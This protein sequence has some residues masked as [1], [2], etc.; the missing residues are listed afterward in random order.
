MEIMIIIVALIVGILPLKTKK[1]L[2]TRS[3]SLMIAGVVI[4][5]AICLYAN[6]GPVDST[7]D[8]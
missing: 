4:L 7:D 3:I 8:D 5:G 1:G 2:K 6:I